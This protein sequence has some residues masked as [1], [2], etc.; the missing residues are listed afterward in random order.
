MSKLSGIRNVDWMTVEGLDARVGTQNNAKI[1]HDCYSHDVTVTPHSSVSAIVSSEHRYL[2]LTNG[3][4]I[5][6]VETVI[7]PCVDDLLVLMFFAQL[8]CN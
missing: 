3:R 6:L 8:E 4:G 7:S 2:G 5:L 1:M